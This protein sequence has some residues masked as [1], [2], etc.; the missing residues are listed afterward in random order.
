[1]KIRANLNLKL[2]VI[3]KQRYIEDIAPSPVK[4]VT[5]KLPVGKIVKF[6]YPFGND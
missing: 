6:L 2:F 4:N 3:P 5:I 1:M